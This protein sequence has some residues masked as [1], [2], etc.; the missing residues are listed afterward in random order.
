ME[1]MPVPPGFTR[2][3]S[4]T[5]QMVQKDSPAE[6]PVQ[7]VVDARRNSDK[8]RKSLHDRPWVNYNETYTIS[9]SED[10]EIPDQVLLLV[11][12]FCIIRKLEVRLGSFLLL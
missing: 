9:D 6:A 2:L 8:L 11:I 5:L 1:D 12:F 10:E 7:S 3:T 4:F